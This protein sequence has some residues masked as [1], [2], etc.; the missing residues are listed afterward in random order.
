M[1]PKFQ[2]D[3]QFASHLPVCSTV[4][5]LPSSDSSKT[6]LQN[7]N[8]QIQIHRPGYNSLSSLCNTI[9]LQDHEKEEIK[10]IMLQQD[11]TFKHQVYW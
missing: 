5:G 3:M 11:A 9:Q 10:K 2:S 1:K 8:D 4:E 7:N 6:G